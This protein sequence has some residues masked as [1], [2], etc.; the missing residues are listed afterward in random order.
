MPNVAI[1]R[2]ASRDRRGLQHGRYHGVTRSEDPQTVW[3]VLLFGASFGLGL[4]IYVCACTCAC[5]CVDFDGRDRAP[6]NSEP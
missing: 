6:R 4:G 3:L 1:G 5:A 2:N